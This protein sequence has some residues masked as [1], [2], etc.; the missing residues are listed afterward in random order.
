MADPA[1]VTEVSRRL[2]ARCDAINGAA[3]L[4][5][6]IATG[7]T[8]LGL[9]P[10]ASSLGGRAACLGPVPGAVA[11]ALLVP[12]E[13]TTVGAAVDEAFMTATP[14]QL[15]GGAPGGCHPL[16]RGE[17]RR[18]AAGHRSGVGPA[19]PRD[20]AVAGCRPS[21]VRRPA[22]APVAR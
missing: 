21:D 10:A 9:G 17:A 13:P 18:P 11:A 3:F 2:K 7:F 14:E 15:V 19:A 16:S 20:R 6:E 12:L 8:E 5:P 4:M 1:T 22:V